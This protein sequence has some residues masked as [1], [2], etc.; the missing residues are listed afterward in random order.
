MKPG[1]TLL[2]LFTLGWLNG[3]AYISSIQSDVERH[4][5][6][7][8]AQQEYARALGVL[9]H[10]RPKHPR[11]KSLMALKKTIEK[12]AMAYERQEVKEA[13]KL[14]QDEQWYAALQVF[15]RALDRLP[16]SIYLQRAYNKFYARRDSR[17]A[18]LERELLIARGA[19]LSQSLSIHRAFKETAPEKRHFRTTI[20]AWQKESQEVGE[21][22]EKFGL[23]ALHQR[24]LEL[25][26]RTL[27]LAAKLTPSSHLERANKQLEQMLA[28][29]QQKR[30]SA[31][32][33]KQRAQLLKEYHQTM[34][35]NDL[36]GARD[37]IL[38]L[39]RLDKNNPEIQQLRVNLDKSIAKVVKQEVDAGSTYYSQRLF[40]QAL[41]HWR[42]AQ[43]LSP[44]DETIKAH[45]DRAN[46][47]LKKVAELE[48]KQ[49]TE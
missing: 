13:I 26:Q 4:I 43:E 24:D 3:C 37:L 20:E 38:Q 48:E 23:R 30:R 31:K 42:R 2:L 33:R 6:G 8:R 9:E 19:W 44:H 7:L 12:E 46:R 21:E 34:A 18:E 45:I 22:L 40:E 1:R 29:D 5:E 47:V 10:I 35:Q 36:K 11:Y 27:P 49:K 16:D 41:I 25:A 17:I 32:I 14:E 39:E 15:H 28:A